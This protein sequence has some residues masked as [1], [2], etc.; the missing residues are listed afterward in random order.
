M[1]KIIAG[2]AVLFLFFSCATVKETEPEKVFK[3]EN[4][5]SNRLIYYFAEKNPGEE[6]FCA[7]IIT[8]RDDISRVEESM[9][10]LFV[11]EES[12]LD[13]FCPVAIY[14][15]GQTSAM[16]VFSLPEDITEVCVLFHSVKKH[17]S[18][19]KPAFPTRLPH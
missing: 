6:K 17:R 19:P 18:G 3:S 16:A 7:Y 9:H 13:D 5:R 1:K 2:F 12:W 8:N 15:D 14:A 4:K 11:N 10:G